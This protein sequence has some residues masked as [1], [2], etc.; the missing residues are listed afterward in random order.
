MS[1][2]PVDDRARAG[3]VACWEVGGLG[4]VPAAGLLGCLSAALWGLFSGRFWLGWANTREGLRLRFWALW[5][6]RLSRS[7]VL[8]GGSAGAPGFGCW[9]VLGGRD[10]LGGWVDRAGL[11]LDVEPMGCG[12]VLGM[13]SRRSA[14][15]SSECFRVLGPCRGPRDAAR[16]ATW[17]HKKTP[18]KCG[19]SGLLLALL[20]LLSLLCFL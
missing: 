14:F 8:L 15:E 6:A 12:E 2:A 4:L 13:M 3:A 16:G 7:A 18:H 10:V 11:G 19:A 1:R 9:E 5:C 17:R 20:S